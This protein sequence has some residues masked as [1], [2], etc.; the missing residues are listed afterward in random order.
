MENDLRTIK[1]I[2]YDMPNGLSRD[3]WGSIPL[4]TTSEKKNGKKSDI[5]HLSN[6][7]LPPYP[8]N[9]IWKNDKSQQS[10]GPSLLEERMTY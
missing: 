1:L 6:Y 8:K 7:P 2:M 4:G 10:V 3:Q 5:V 9:D